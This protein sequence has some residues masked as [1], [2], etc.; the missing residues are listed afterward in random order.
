MKPG[1]AGPA[2]LASLLAV[3][4][5]LPIPSDPVS[6]LCFAYSGP[7][8]GAFLT[9]LL[10]ILDLPGLRVRLPSLVLDSG[11]TSSLVFYLLPF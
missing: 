9:L 11:C 5:T 7:V 1:R 10:S 4:L 2:S 3:A 8:A 6:L